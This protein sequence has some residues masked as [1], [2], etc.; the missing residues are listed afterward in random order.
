MPDFEEAFARVFGDVAGVQIA[1]AL[2][3]GLD[4][5]RATA[6][7]LLRDGAEFLTEES[8]DLVSKPELDAFLDDVDELR[9]AV[10]RFERR[11]TRVAQRGS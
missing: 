4:A 8:R 7:A 1:R 3:S 9:D 6:G 2:K 11:A 10:E 5:A